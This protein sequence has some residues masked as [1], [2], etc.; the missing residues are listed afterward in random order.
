MIR[1]A[2]WLTTGAVVGAGGTVWA[3]RRLEALSERVRSG[4]VSADV[5]S[6]AKRG[7]GAGASRVRRAVEAGK[8]SARRREDELWD[9][10]EVRARGR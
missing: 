6:I 5:V 9:E 10:L 1:R 8:L 4:D 3:R 2:L 7:A